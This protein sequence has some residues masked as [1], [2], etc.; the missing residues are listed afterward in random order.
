MPS[1][2]KT[3]PVRDA[4]RMFPRLRPCPRWPPARRPTQNGGSRPG[5]VGARGSLT[6]RWL[7]AAPCRTTAHPIAALICLN[8]AQP[9]ARLV[10]VKIMTTAQTI[11][12][13]EAGLETEFVGWQAWRGVSGLFY[14]RR[15]LSS[16][17]IVVRAGSL[18]DLRERVKEHLAS[19]ERPLPVPGPRRLEHLQ[20][21]PGRRLA[22][23]FPAAH[24]TANC[25]GGWR[26]ARRSPLAVALPAPQAPL[27]LQIR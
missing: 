26:P 2:G 15:R 7:S 16:P 10:S 19:K 13:P 1:T 4:H 18:E 21:G 22:V 25:L 11:H 9:A 5:P 12:G 6:S 23:S 27:A 24:M 20:E 3:L 17:P 14:A 8:T